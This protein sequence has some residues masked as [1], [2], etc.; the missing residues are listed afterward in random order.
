MQ[1]RGPALADQCGPACTDEGRTVILRCRL[2]PSIGMLHVDQ[3]GVKKN[4]STARV[5]ASR[6]GGALWYESLMSCIPDSTWAPRPHGED[7]EKD[8]DE[9]FPQVASTSF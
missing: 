8:E 9:E 4:D 6:G 2:L 1:A 5:Q 3:N 7:E